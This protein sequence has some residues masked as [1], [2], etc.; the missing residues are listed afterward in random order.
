MS[1]ASKEQVLKQ[2]KIVE[3]KALA[4]TSLTEMDAY[5]RIIAA[6]QAELRAKP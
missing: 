2:L 4:A 3:K 1:A 6:L 5:D